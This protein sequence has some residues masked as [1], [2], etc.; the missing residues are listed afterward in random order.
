VVPQGEAVRFNLT[1]VDVIHGFWIP[2]VRFKR[3]VFP[4]TTQSVTL[5]FPRA[6]SFQ[7]QCSQ[8][9]G[10]RHADMLFDVRVVAPSAFVSWARSGG[11]AALG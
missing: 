11:K 4:S 10:L 8:F 1:S 3:D 6:G 9:C 7:G 5:V 2:E